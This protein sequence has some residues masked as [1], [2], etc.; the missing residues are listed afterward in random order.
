MMGL[1]DSS[2]PFVDGNLFL[3]PSNKVRASE[4]VSEG[5]CNF[6]VT[7]SISQS[8]SQ[9]PSTHPSTSRSIRSSAISSFDAF[10][11]ASRNSTYRRHK[12]YVEPQRVST[13]I[14]AFKRVCFSSWAEGIWKRI[15]RMR[16]RTHALTSR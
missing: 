8:K 1:F 12:S 9:L 14:F 7:E 10:S 13:S 15:F 5:S 2:L 4:M 16:W 11:N 3:I 6:F